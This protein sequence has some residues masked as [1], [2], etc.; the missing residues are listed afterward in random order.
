M[1]PCGLGR[2]PLMKHCNSKN[3][4]SKSHSTDDLAV[5]HFYEFGNVA[6]EYDP[7]YYLEAHMA[8]K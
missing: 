3:Y 6:Y 5:T 1:L 4:N 2:V 7:K 8:A